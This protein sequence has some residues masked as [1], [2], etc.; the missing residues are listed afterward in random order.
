MS[1]YP[2][3]ELKKEIS[4]NVDSSSSSKF[5]VVEDGGCPISNGLKV[6]DPLRPKGC[7]YRD[8]KCI[9][10]SKYQCNKTSMIY[11]I[12]CT[13]CDSVIEDSNDSK[14]SPNYIGLTRSSLHARMSSSLFM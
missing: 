3:G 4:K 7:I 9:V 13:S 8:P 11:K 6:N 12:T 10:D 5:L 2:S 1:Y 14:E